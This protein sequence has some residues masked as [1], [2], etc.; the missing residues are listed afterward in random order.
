MTTRQDLKDKYDWKE[1]FTYA[2][3]FTV[4]DVVEIKNAVERENDGDDWI[5]LGRLRSG[6]WFYLKAGC[7]YTGWEC[8]IKAELI[9]M[10]MDENARRRFGI[11]VPKV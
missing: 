1:A 7:D 4:E 2:Q 3:G 11:P 9:R 10:G 8:R 5:I 6:A